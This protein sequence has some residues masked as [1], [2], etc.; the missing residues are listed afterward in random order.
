MMV[1][2]RWW[3][4]C[5]YCYCWLKVSC[6]CDT[7][8]CVC[9]YMRTITVLYAFF[10]HTCSNTIKITG[11][12]IIMLGNDQNKWLITFIR[13]FTRKKFIRLALSSCW[14]FTRPYF[15]LSPIYP[16]IWIHVCSAHCAHRCLL[17][18]HCHYIYTCRNKFQLPHACIYLTNRSI[19]IRKYSLCTC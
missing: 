10:Y 4:N 9:V 17:L 1:I 19:F 2:M 13:T 11:I 16:Y 3:W 12:N 14:F 15:L 5:Y 18:A 7:C 6:W 8:V